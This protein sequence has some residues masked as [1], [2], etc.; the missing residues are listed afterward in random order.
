MASSQAGSDAGLTAGNPDPREDTGV[1]CRP[2]LP[3]FPIRIEKHGLDYW[4]YE[5]LPGGFRRHRGIFRE[6]ARARGYVARV[7]PGCNVWCDMG[8]R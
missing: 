6:Y 8:E 1:P 7:L 4:V 5:T 2:S 3:A